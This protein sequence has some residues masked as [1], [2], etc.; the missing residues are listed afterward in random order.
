M[1]NAKTLGILPSQAWPLFEI[2]LASDESVILL[3]R[4]AG[5]IELANGLLYEQEFH[6]PCEEQGISVKWAHF[7]NNSAQNGG[8]I[9]SRGLQNM[10]VTVK[11]SRFEHNRALGVRGGAI[12]GSGIDVG[13]RIQDSEFKHNTAGQEEGEEHTSNPGSGGG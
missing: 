2:R 7:R 6:V 5:P 3:D 8:A 1:T 9:A 10:A 4:D 13:L 11:H 12:A